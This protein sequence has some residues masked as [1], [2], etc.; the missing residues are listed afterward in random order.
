M[1]E[2]VG[3]AKLAMVAALEREV[4]PLVKGWARKKRQHGGRVLTFLEQDGAVLICGGIGAQAARRAAEAVIELYRPAAVYSVG[5]AGALEKDLKVGD[6]F[7]PSMVLDAR[8]GSRTPLS[9]ADGTLITFMEVAGAGQKAK[10]AKAYAACAVDMEAAAVAAAAHAHGIACH[11]IKV[12]SDELGFEIPHSP[13]FIGGDGQF[14]TMRFI[15]FAA[16]RPWIWRRVATLARNATVAARVLSAHLREVCEA[17]TPIE[18]SISS[19]ALPG[20]GTR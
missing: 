7:S 15:L 3:K 14:E 10:L 19:A 20:G 2:P 16:L 8:D 17:S 5:F 6:I 11:A 13:S 1:S 9:G 18:L 4:G 12:I